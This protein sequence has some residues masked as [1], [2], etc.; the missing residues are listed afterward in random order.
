MKRALIDRHVLDPRQGVILNAQT[1][2]S[3]AS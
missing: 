2:K 3:D 1:T